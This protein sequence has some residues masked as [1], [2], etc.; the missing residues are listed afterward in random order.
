MENNSS[1]T[2]KFKLLFLGN[3]AVGKTSLLE[4]FVDGTFED[5]DIS[6]I[7][8]D[9]KV[10]YIEMNQKK[11][12][13]E[14]WDTAGQERFHSIA[15]NYIRGGNGF[16][17]V[18]AVNSRNSFKGIKKWIKDARKMQSI[19]NFQMIIVG[20]KCDLVN[21]EDCKRKKENEVMQKELQQLSQEFGVLGIETSAKNDININKMFHQLINNLLL[22]QNEIE[23]VSSFG[24]NTALPHS[25]AI[26]SEDLS[27]QTI[28]EKSKCAC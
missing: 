10:K 4:R 23:N 14:I 26:D 19:K 16:I 11:I 15:K 9:H 20:N 22:H 25:F 5:K 24:D 17:F 28:Q 12:K 27:Q 2:L 3:S 6:T 13:L 21:E 1:K 7:G 18:Y 8:I